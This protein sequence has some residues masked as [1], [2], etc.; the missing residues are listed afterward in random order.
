M[1]AIIDHNQRRLAI[2]KAVEAIVS[3]SGIQTVTFR[4]VGKE[5][6]FSHTVVNH[7]FANKLDLLKFT[8]TH[9]RM[10]SI[11]RVEEMLA[12]GCN[13]HTCLSQCLPT[14]S[15]RQSEWK[16]WFGFWGMVTEN[17]EL[18][19]EQSRGVTESF[20]LFERVFVAAQRNGEFRE[21]LDVEFL[22]SRAQYLIDGIACLALQMPELWTAE[23]QLTALQDELNLMDKF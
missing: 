14:D 18:K 10:R 12:R 7:Y 23:R 16:V 19:E 8:Y 5:A 9:A 11:A 22:A 3:R 6:G 1:P 20:S 21:E 13:A 4:E 17:P 2:A 15:E